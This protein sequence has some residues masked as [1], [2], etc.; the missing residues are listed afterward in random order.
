MRFGDP[1]C[2]KHLPRRVPFTARCCWAGNFLFFECS[3]SSRIY[4]FMHIYM[5]EYMCISIHTWS[6]AAANIYIYIIRDFPCDCVDSY[7]QNCKTDSSDIDGC[8]TKCSLMM[9]LRMGLASPSIHLCIPSY[10]YCM[11]T[12]THT[13]I[14]CHMPLYLYLY[15]HL[16]LHLHLHLYLWYAGG[17]GW[18]YVQNTYAPMISP[19]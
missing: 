10:M 19:E 9:Q 2:G 6:T 7:G 13:M 12:L 16:H 3:G 15:L 4:A 8:E 14:V 11:P 17:V 5:H 1:G 18:C